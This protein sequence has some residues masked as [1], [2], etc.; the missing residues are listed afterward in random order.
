MIEEIGRITGKEPEAKGIIT[1]INSRF[2]KLVPSGPSIKVCYLIWQEPYMSIGN[3][4]FIHDMLSRCGFQNIFEDETRYPMTSLEDIT[5]RQCDVVFL[6]S[7]PFPF[8]DTHAATM[9]EKL[10]GIRIEL[11]DG[12]MFTWYG[13]RMRQSVPYFQS[14][15][16]TLQ[17]AP[18]AHR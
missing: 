7:E 5:A 9:R 8:N 11:V 12:E 3:D 10:P 2:R 17:H 1:D 6:A 18:G 14:L 13:S 4:T 16:D 15:I